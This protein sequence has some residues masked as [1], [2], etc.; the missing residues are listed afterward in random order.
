MTKTILRL[1]AV[2]TEF[3]LLIARREVDRQS[4]ELCTARRQSPD[5]FCSPGKPRKGT[6]N[7]GCDVPTA[8]RESPTA[9]RGSS[10]RPDG[11]RV[12]GEPVFLRLSGSLLRLSGSLLRLSG[13]LLQL[14]GSLL[15]LSGSLLR[16]SG[17]FLQVSGSL[18]RLSGNLLRGVSLPL[19][20]LYNRSIALEAITPNLLASPRPGQD[21]S[22]LYRCMSSS[23]RTIFA[24]LGQIIGTVFSTAKSVSPSRQPR[25]PP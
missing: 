13:S 19:P 24:K 21:T 10:L 5:G 18:L 17:K 16:L 15:Q 1:P 8:L 2:T 4:C 25:P 3:G 12:S 7:A 20:G 9:L 23:H 14:S 6:Q 11:T 22:W